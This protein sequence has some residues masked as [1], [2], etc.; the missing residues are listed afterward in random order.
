MASLIVLGGY[1][2]D[3]NAWI[4][5]DSATGQKYIWYEDSNETY[6]YNGGGGA[7]L[8]PFISGNT[9][10]TGG[11]GGYIQQGQSWLNDLLNFGLGLAAIGNRGTIQG[12]AINPAAQPQGLPFSAEAIAAAQARSQQNLGGN[13]G[14]SLQKF[15]TQNTGLLLIGGVAFVLWKSG[16]K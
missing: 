9:S 8:P 4:V 12:G 16:R 13:F 1:G 15:I 2:N 6:P 7:T 5:Q 10:T 3:P 11:S 14:A